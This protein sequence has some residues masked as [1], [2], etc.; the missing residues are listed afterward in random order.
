[1]T[2]TIVI[3]IVVAFFAC[4]LILLYAMLVMV[5]EGDDWDEDYWEERCMKCDRTTELTPSEE[6][7]DG[8][9]NA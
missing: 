1:M 7:V 8:A 6:G 9:P 2:K 5:S 4:S 3:G